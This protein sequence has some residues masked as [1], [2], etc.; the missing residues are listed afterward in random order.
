[1]K[2]KRGRKVS[3]EVSSTTVAA[4]MVIALLVS[5]S[6][7]WV[8]NVYTDA[9]SFSS[10]S[11]QSGNVGDVTLHLLE[12]VSSGSSSIANVGLVIGSSGEE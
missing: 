2:K 12:A 3:Q 8:V 7:T 10:G 4:L 11:F 1:M 5:I 6:G 9:T